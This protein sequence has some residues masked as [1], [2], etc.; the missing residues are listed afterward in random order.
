MKK[1][2]LSLVSLLALCLASRGETY[3]YDFGVVN[4]DNV[5]IYYKILDDNYPEHSVGVT[6]GENKYV[7]DIEIPPTVKYGKQEYTVVKINNSAFTHGD[8]LYLV[9]SVTLPETIIEIGYG[10]CMAT[11]NIPSSVTTINSSSVDCRTVSNIEYVDSIYYVGHIALMPDFGHSHHLV[12][13]E[14]TKIIADNF[15]G[16][17]NHHNND[18]TSIVLP[19]S[20]THIGEHAFQYCKNL[21]SVTI[22]N[23]VTSIGDYA[24]YDCTSLTSVT[25]PNSVTSIGNYAFSWCTGLTSVTIGNSVTSIGAWAFSNC[26]AL[27]SVTI[28]NSVTSIGWHT[29]GGCKGLTSVTIPNSVTSI[30]YETFAGCSSLT[31]ITIP[32]S[33]TSIRDRAF[34]GCSSLTS[35]TIPSSVTSIG[36]DAFYNCSNLN[37]CVVP[38]GSADK[39]KSVLPKCNVVELNEPIEDVNADT[40]VNTVDVVS[41]YNYITNGTGIASYHA[42]VNLD[43]SVNT[44]DVVAIYEHIIGNG[45]ENEYD[46][47]FDCNNPEATIY[48]DGVDLGQISSSAY[49]LS[50]GEHTIRL[51]AIGYYD[52]EETINVTGSTT[53]TLSQEVKY[54]DIT[55]ECNNADATIYIDGI[56]KGKISTS[57]YSLSY[58]THTIRLTATGY[59]DLEETINVTGSATM[60]LSRELVAKMTFTVNGVS[61]KMVSVEGGTFQMGSTDGDDYEKPVHNVTLSSYSIGE[62]E[63][64]QALWT[65]VMGTNPSYF[66]GDNLPVEKVTWNDCQTFITKLNQLTGNSFRL[67]T[68]AEWEFAAKGGTKS[69]GYTYSGS[70]TIGDVA[71][72]A[73][74]SSRTHPVATKQANELGIYDMSGNVYE[75]CQDWLGDYRRS[76]QSNPTGPTSGSS[77]VLRGGSWIDGAGTAYRL[78]SNPD[79]SFRDLGLRLAL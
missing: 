1:F 12:F 66:K 62:T 59:D 72:Y 55:F 9:T 3:K 75:W 24:F 38:K 31:S 60:T 52:L 63:V 42:D 41:V 45:G 4:D 29:F 26:E 44:A 14:G 19:N 65:A 64:T 43:G 32:N 49:S 35:V 30:E 67:P 50:I 22:P 78:S 6:Y 33:V 7:G 15:M 17:Q 11:I 79:C 28:P 56:N 5:T 25:I 16:N 58:G 53:I 10:A 21:T 39:Y 57:A 70:N 40:K 8:A 34:A 76:A 48:I 54:Y 23:S 20:L 13:R 68:E 36:N 77:R 73:D 27:T 46:V 71:W 74:N 18:C 37:T 51:S 47:T 2:I 61:F 69:K